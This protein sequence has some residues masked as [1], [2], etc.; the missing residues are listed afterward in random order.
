[1]ILTSQAQCLV[2]RIL[3]YSNRVWWR[4]FILS[5]VILELAIGRFRISVHAIGQK[6]V[7]WQ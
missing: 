6:Y 3:V 5:F 2:Q 7:R 1:M 4:H